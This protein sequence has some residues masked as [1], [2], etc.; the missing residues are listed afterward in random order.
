MHDEKLETLVEMVEAANGSPVLV[1][2]GFKHEEARIM[3]AL[4]PFGAR[5]LNTV[6]DEGVER[7]KDTRTSNAPGERGPRA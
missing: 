5:R 7:G 2:Y 3:K 1:A 4:Q 6:D